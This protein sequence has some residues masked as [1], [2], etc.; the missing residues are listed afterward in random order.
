MIIGPEGGFSEN[1]INFA[2][3]KDFK[4][5]KIG[6]RILKSETAAISACTLLQ[7]FFGDMNVKNS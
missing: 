1:E 7:Y 6:P 2:K 3:K 5:A 4:I